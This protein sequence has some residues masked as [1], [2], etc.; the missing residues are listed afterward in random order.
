MP[1]DANT[2]NFSV[3]LISSGSEKSSSD[4]EIEVNKF[5]QP[6]V[7]PGTVRKRRIERPANASLAADSMHG[8]DSDEDAT[9]NEMMGK[10]DESYC[11]EKETDIL[12]WLTGLG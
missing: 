1:C 11:Y 10:F 8:P 7:T 5:G 9:F 3:K 6:I 12:R 4:T 2:V